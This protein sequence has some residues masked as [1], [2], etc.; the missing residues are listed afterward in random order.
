M[1]KQKESRADR[2][3]NEEYR[4]AARAR[5]KRR[6]ERIKNDPEFKERARQMRAKMAALYPEKVAARRALRTALDSGV[7]IRNPCVVCG[8]RKSHGHHEDYSRPLDVVWLCTKHHAE[9]HREIR[10]RAKQ[11]WE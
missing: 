11:E 8:E 7:M 4:N 9:R 6:Y 10:L 3:L 1:S 5:D 2:R